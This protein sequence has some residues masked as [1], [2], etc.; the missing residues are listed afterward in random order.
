MPMIGVSEAELK[1]DREKFL[2][3]IKKKRKK[4]IL[5]HLMSLFLMN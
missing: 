4:T 5:T 3:F 2:K 1:Q